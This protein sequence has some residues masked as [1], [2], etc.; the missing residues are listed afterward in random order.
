MRDAKC[1]V[2]TSIHL[3]S[4]LELP[5]QQPTAPNMYNTN[6]TSGPASGTFGPTSST[7]QPYAVGRDQSFRLHKIN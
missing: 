4:N 2:S 1:N 7:I 6:M 5:P 3:Y